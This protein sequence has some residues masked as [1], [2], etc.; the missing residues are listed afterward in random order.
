MLTMLHHAL[1]E[2]GQMYTPE[3]FELVQYLKKQLKEKLF[4]MQSLGILS[5][6]TMLDPRFKKLG[7]FSPH[8]ASEAERRL[9]SEC[10][11]TIRR[12]S[13][14]SSASSSASSTSPLASSSFTSE[15]S[16]PQTQGN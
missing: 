12:A 4:N 5:M 3:G 15:T 11:A 16:Q 10:A 6:S 14:S 7:F 2:E 1:E 8:K 9:T 13:S